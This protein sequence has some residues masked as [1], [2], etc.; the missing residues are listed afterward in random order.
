MDLVGILA[1]CV[2]ANASTMRRMQSPDRPSQ[3]AVYETGCQ[4]D[5]LEYMI[6]G[7]IKAH[8]L[9]RLL[10]WTWKAEQAAVAGDA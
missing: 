10:P 4:T 5:V 2:A 3:T 9:E 6:S 7:Q 1:D 8:E